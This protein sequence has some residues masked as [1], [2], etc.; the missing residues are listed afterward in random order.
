MERKIHR[1]FRITPEQLQHL[2]KQSERY[3][4]NHS[5]YIRKLL[6][7]D[8]GKNHG[9]YTKEEFLVKKQLIYEINRI[10]NNINQIVK[11]VNMNFYSDY[12]KKKLFAMMKKLLELMEEQEGRNDTDG[13]VDK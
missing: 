6:D 8:M 2:E 5:Q 9:A 13:R 1:N 7:E 3:N 12:E 11:N 10:G 4:G